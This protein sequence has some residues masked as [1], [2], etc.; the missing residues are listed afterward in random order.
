MSAMSNLVFEID[1]AL[2]D[3][4][5]M[6]VIDA[7]ALEIIAKRLGCPVSWVKDRYDAMCSDW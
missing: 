4:M 7:N 3:I 2:A 1:E 5:Y 6:K